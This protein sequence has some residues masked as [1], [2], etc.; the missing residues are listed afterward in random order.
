MV[1]V[2]LIHEGVDAYLPLLAISPSR[3][4]VTPLRLT[5]GT[6]NSMANATLPTGNRTSAYRLPGKWLMKVCQATRP[7]LLPHGE[8]RVRPGKP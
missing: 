8:R 5:I 2:H 6:K 7:Y 4:S 1:V 3:S